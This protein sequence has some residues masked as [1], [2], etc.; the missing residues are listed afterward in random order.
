[1]TKEKLENIVQRLSQPIERKVFVGL[2]GYVD[3]II[4]V[5]QNRDAAKNPVHFSTIEAFAKRV[6]AA[7]GRSA[8]IELSL[9]ATK[10]GGNGPIMSNAL[11]QLQVPTVCMGTLGFPEIHPVFEPLAEKCELLSLEQPAETS[12]FEFSDGKLMFSNIEPFYRLSWDYLV[13]QVGLEKL[14]SSIAAAQVIALVDWSNLVNATQIWQGILQDVLPALPTAE[15][16]FLFDLCD[17][18]AQSDEELQEMLK[19]VTAYAKYGLVT[20]GLNK[21]ELARL[22]QLFPATDFPTTGNLEQQGSWLYERLDIDRLLLHQA[23]RVVVLHAS[24]ATAVEGHLVE[25]PKLLTGAGDN[26]NA[27]YCFGQLLGCDLE[28]CIHL[29]IATAGAYVTHGQSPD[30]QVLEEYLRKWLGQ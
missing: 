9:Q 18:N 16:Y 21:N 19:V 11:S 4:R 22:A 3:K 12:A 28:A 5:V 8:Q 30:R 20:L 6:A 24:G 17:P 13:E 10:M 2:D 27:G 1:M 26:L 7:A 23:D 25:Q 14:R 29:G 15:R